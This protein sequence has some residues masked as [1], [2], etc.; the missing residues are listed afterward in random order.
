[1]SLKEDMARVLEARR[2]GRAPAV[3]QPAPVKDLAYYL[4]R[5]FTDACE[6]DQDREASQEAGWRGLY[7]AN[8]LE[9]L[10]AERESRL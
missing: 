2:T 7:C 8:C 10:A 9:E 1:V 6:N 4:S 5:C 3:E